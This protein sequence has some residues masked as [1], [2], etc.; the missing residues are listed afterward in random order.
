MPKIGREELF[1]RAHLLTC[2]T[3]LFGEARVSLLSIL[4]LNIPRSLFL[5]S[6][7]LS[8]IVMSFFPVFFEP[9]YP[10]FSFAPLYSSLYSNF[11][12]HP[13]ILVFVFVFSS[14]QHRNF[15]I[16]MFIVKLVLFATTTTPCERELIRNSVYKPIVLVS[17]TT[18]RICQ[19]H[20]IFSYNK[21]GSCRKKSKR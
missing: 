3:L 12:Q 6:S 8:S 7:L 11:L 13:F 9:L 14:F 4:T 1:F 17:P 15:I 10:F 18:N 5:P 19:M 16:I 21:H 2:Q 20:R